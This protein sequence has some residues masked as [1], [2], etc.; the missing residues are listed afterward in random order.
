M[1]MAIH[2]EKLTRKFRRVRA[3]DG[4]D[5]DVPDG[6]I[7]TLVGPN[8]AGKT[9]AIKILMNI[10]RATSGRAE[11]LNLDSR[12]I[13]GKA[14][15]TIGYVSENQELPLWMRVGGFL[16][17]LRP[18][19]PTWDRDLELELVRQ[20]ALPLD[21]KLRHLSRGMRTKAALAG[22]LAYHPRLI[23]LDEPFTGLDPLVRDELIAGMLERSAEASVLIAS[24]DLAEIES[25]A[26]HVGYLDQGRLQ[27]S[28]DMT[29]LANRFREVDLTL[30]APVVLPERL[31]ATWMQASAS[32]TAV[33]FIES[34]F[35]QERTSAEIRRVFGET[36]SV[37]FIPM[38]L[39]SIF[40]A[41][42]RTGRG[43][44]ERNLESR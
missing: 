36:R 17:Y 26:S 6:A 21:R 25:F 29:A 3:L 22:S 15:Q 42:A 19:Y 37:A 4:L 44:E 11:V 8:G 5:L 41:M 32:S 7:Y 9:T 28:E 12:R 35:D 16:D 38:S 30:P 14:F 40:L 31:P 43:P 34:R 20:F 24:H 27:F 33:Q 18:F 23:V 1:S 2:A 13:A 39:R 10:I